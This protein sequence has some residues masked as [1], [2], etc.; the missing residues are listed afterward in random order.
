M[1][2][3]GSPQ[4]TTREEAVYGTRHHCI[5]CRRAVHWMITC[6]GGRPLPFDLEPLPVR[7]DSQHTGWA[8]G[9]FP[10]GGRLRRCMAP[11]TKFTPERQATLS[12]V[13]TVHTCPQTP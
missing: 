12:I 10:I 2:T 1:P 13:L 6:R 5:R 4:V 7:Y 11:W 9:M 8:P 3:L